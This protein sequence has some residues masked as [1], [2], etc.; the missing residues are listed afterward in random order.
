[1]D[2]LAAFGDSVIYTEPYTSSD[3]KSRIGQGIVYLPTRNRSGS[4]KC[5]N[6]VTGSVVT[7]DAI[8]VVPTTTATIK[9]MNDLA[10]LDGRYMPRIPP[11]IHDMIY[12]QS[13]AKINTPTFSPVNPTSGTWAFWP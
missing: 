13:V 8:T 2:F 7:L 11:A 1:M 10:A 9:I 5:L 4:F 6:L 3:M 12:N